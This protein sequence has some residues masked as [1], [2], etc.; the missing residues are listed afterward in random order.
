MKKVSERNLKSSI[1]S[2]IMALLVIFLYYSIPEDE[3]NSILVNLST[4]IIG[5]YILVYKVSHNTLF[6]FKEIVNGYDCGAISPCL[7]DTRSA[8]AI[9]VMIS[10]IALIGWGTIVGWLL[11]TFSGTYF[12]ILALLTAIEGYVISYRYMSSNAID[13]H[14]ENA[15]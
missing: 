6:R 8:F 2:L 14:S 10:I 3:R 5:I 12:A 4:T 15:V 13:E 7:T 11:G 9:S 1:I